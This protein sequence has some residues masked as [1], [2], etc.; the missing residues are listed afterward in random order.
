MSRLLCIWERRSPNVTQGGRGWVGARLGAP[1][2][3]PR[4]CVRPPVFLYP[5]AAARGER[6]ARVVPV[7]VSCLYACDARVVP[8]CVRCACRARDARR[9]RERVIRFAPLGFPSHTKKNPIKTITY[10]LFW[11]N[12]KKLLTL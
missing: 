5:R 10:Q 11:A 12:V 6:D 3:D 9:E 7:R 2:D 1:G 8:V 4:P